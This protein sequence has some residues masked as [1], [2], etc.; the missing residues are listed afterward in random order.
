MKKLL[1]LLAAVF[2][3]TL[4]LAQ[5]GLEGIIVEK[6]YVS[7]SA[8]SAGSIGNLPAGSVTY[9]VWVDMLPGY[10]FQALYGVPGHS[11]TIQTSTTFF[12]NEDYGGLAAPFTSSTNIRKNTVLLDSYFSVGG[13]AT[14]KVG[15]FKSDDSDGSPGNANNILQNNDI[16]ASGPINIG[17]T[18]SLAAQDGMIT[19]TPASVTFVGL[20]NTGNGDLGVFDFTSQTG[21]LFTTSNGSIA[22]LGGVVGP[23]A[24]NRVLIGQFTTD[25]NFSFQLNVQIGTPGGGVQNYVAS[26][27]TGSE[28]VI[29]SL[30][31]P[32]VLN[33]GVSIAANPAGPICSKTSV[34]FTATPVNGGTNP[35]YQWKK[36][37]VNVGT[38]SPTYTN[39]SLIN[40]DQ[41]KCI[42]T[43]NLPGV[44]G[45]PATS[46]TI[47]MQVN[48]VP[49]ATI[50]P[51]GPTTYCSG[52][53]AL[54]LTANSGTGLTYQWKKGT[55]N[56]NNA[57]N[58]N[59]T[60]TAA[61]TFTYKVLV[62]N[63][64]GC[65]KLSPGISVTVNPLPAAGIT[66]S[67]PLNI[68]AGDSV[69]LTANSGTGLT[70]QW[71]KGTNVISGATGQTYT[72]KTAGSYKVLV[73]NAYGC[74]KLSAGKSF[75]IV[76]RQ[77]DDAKDLNT[78]ILQISPNPSKGLFAVHLTDIGKSEGLAEIK[79][80]N[81]IGQ[82]VYA[83]KIQYSD[84]S[85]DHNIDL[86]A[87]QPQGLYLIR[88]QLDNQELTT[89]ILI[90]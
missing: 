30:T 62:T 46:N 23:T 61:G 56:I 40:N 81:A 65:T 78:A 85:L 18:T 71:K 11:L 73:A 49:S 51:T 58:I 4:S 6:Y 54:V 50:T 2:V 82:E 27:P 31:Y 20:S 32:L 43:S 22:A 35:T 74:T 60:P 12:N 64:S 76:C 1:T 3:V 68:C 34:T 83:E 79:V 89:R 8:D 67:G 86:T 72:A 41:V 15:V 7:N 47:G 75:K 42:M 48:A 90:Q 52:T 17:T 19:G 55:A 37:G 9:R 39:A 36:N 80:L 57:T 5:N 28:I 24:S 45:N 63:S 13:V 29:P 33:A 66:A 14:G 70:Y 53:N 26:N 16:T 21:G 25:G 69:V 88:L 87:I 44:T 10:N 77:D 38:N 84:N 59:Y